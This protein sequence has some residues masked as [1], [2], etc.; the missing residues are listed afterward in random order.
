MTVRTWLVD[1][2]LSCLAASMATFYAGGAYAQTPPDA[3]AGPE[4]PPAAA[5]PAAEAPQVP[6]TEPPPGPAPAPLSPEAAAATDATTTDVQP[7]PEPAPAE[8]AEAAPGAIEAGADSDP[9]FAPTLRWSGYLDIGFFVPRGD[10]AGHQ[11]DLGHLIFPEH[12]SV[13]WV[14]HGDPL[15]TAVNSRGEPADTG[16][17]S[18]ASRAIV[19]DSVDSRGEPGFLVNELNLDLTAGLHERVWLLGSVDLVP[20]GRNISDPNGIMLGDMVE[21]DLAFVNWTAI[22]SDSVVDIQL[23][24]IDSVMGIEYRVQ[25]SPDRFGITPSLIFRYLGGHPLGLKLRGRFFE[26]ALNVALSVTNGSHF[27]E[28]FPFADEQDRNAFKTIAGRVGVRYDGDVQLEVGG[29]GLVGGQDGQPEALDPL[30]W[31]VGADLDFVWLDFELRAEYTRG[32]AP[33]ATESASCDLAPC[34]EF[35][36]AYGELSYRFTN[37]LG[38]LA[39]FDWRDATHRSGEDFLYI[40]DIAR[41]TFGVRLDIDRFF[42]VKAEYVLNLE[43]EDRPSIDN[44]VITTSFVAVF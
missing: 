2:A 21:I 38:G 14:F 29:S 17:S 13:A 43:L 36:G 28:Q 6:A 9:G 44:D 15:S 39:R 40:V 16:D 1:L 34:L 42:I 27:V 37:L 26:E 24:K 8:A 10:G 25:E 7:E 20:R 11:Q 4:L 32:E 5:P 22:D 18:N 30:Q 3:S 12:R 41:G 35:Q 31:Q 33:G 19:F 23:G